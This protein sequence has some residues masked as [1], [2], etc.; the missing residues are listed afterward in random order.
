MY[1]MYDM[2]CS[3][4]FDPH[5]TGSRSVSTTCWHRPKKVVRSRTQSSSKNYPVWRV[6]ACVTLALFAGGGLLDILY[7]STAA[8][9]DDSRSV[10]GQARVECGVRNVGANRQKKTKH[11]TTRRQ[12]YFHAC[13]Y[14]PIKQGTF[15]WRGRRAHHYSLRTLSFTIKK[16]SYKNL[17]LYTSS[18]YIPYYTAGAVHPPKTPHLK[19]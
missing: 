5:L 19:I 11:T 15:L 14:A 9:V 3:L 13:V 8:E 1:G 16:C 12:A 4:R 7:C 18:T 17:I 2:S 10:C 6:L